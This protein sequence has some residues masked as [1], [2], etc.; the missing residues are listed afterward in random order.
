V[1][2]ILSDDLRESIERAGYPLR[3]ASVVPPGLI[4]VYPHP[5][6]VELSGA[7]ERLPYK[8]SKAQRYWPS[9]TPPERRTHFYRQ[10]NEVATLLERE[11]AGV[12]A[13]LPKPQ[14]DASRAELKAYEDTRDAVICAWIAICALEGQAKP[15]GDENSA[16]WIPG[17][18]M[19]HDR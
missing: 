3:T 13:S 14:S 8:V 16:I 9:A 11:I 17:V 6:L 19:A 4:E 5:A 18:A 15:F 7:G 1:L 12:T 10:W 2:G